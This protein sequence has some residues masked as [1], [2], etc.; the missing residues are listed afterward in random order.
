MNPFPSGLMRHD[1]RIA[2]VGRRIGEFERPV[3]GCL[4]IVHG[5]E[6]AGVLLQHEEARMSIGKVSSPPGSSTDA[7]TLAQTVISGS[8]QIVPQVVKTK[9]NGP[10]VSSGASSTPTR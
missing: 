3:C 2:C 8:Q 10:G 5:H 1:G 9:S 7:I 4:E 6:P